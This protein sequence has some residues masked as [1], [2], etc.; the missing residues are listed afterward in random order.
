MGSARVEN[1]KKQIFIYFSNRMPL[2]Y[3][4]AIIHN[5][6]MAKEGHNIIKWTAKLQDHCYNEK[7]TSTVDTILG[8]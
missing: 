5:K 8:N 7:E 4:I 6:T 2:D 1:V 3:C